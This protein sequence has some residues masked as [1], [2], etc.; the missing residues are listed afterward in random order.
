[1]FVSLIPLWL[2]NIFCMISILLK[3]LRFVLWPR[4][5]TI[6][7]KSMC[8]LLF[9]SAVF[10]ISQLE[11]VQIFYIFCRLC[12]LMLLGRR[13]ESLTCRVKSSFRVGPLLWQDSPLL[14]AKERA[15]QAR[16]PAVA[17][18]LNLVPLGLLVSLGGGGEYQA[19][20]MKILPRLGACLDYYKYIS[21]KIGWNYSFHIITL[22]QHCLS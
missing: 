20:R 16:W 17:K 22:F 10:Y 11:F 21:L 2:E 6:L 3:L 12:H 15:S 14:W 9:L 5:S 13:R 18:S 19:C 1:M 8:S 4:I 7:V